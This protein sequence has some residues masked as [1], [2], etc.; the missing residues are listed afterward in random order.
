MHN[1]AAGVP[2]GPGTTRAW[3]GTSIALGG[4][5]WVIDSALGPWSSGLQLSPGSQTANELSRA[6]WSTN[7][8]H[9]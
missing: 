4:R 7:V 5:E 6:N 1:P 8:Q 9:P 2:T 3:F